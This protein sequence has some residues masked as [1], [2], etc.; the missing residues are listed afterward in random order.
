MLPRS[1]HFPSLRVIAAIAEEGRWQVQS[2]APQLG[3][4][5][6]Q[7]ERHFRLLYG[8]S[9]QRWLEDHRLRR[10]C[11]ILRTQ[12]PVKAAAQQL[13]FA[14]ASHFCGWFKRLTALTPTEFAR[15]LSVPV[16][17]RRWSPK[18]RAARM[19]RFGNQLSS[20]RAAPSC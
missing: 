20:R 8:G 13:G 5:V 1:D 6:R 14:T 19:S 3:V 12:C 7:L 18:K 17:P 15:M 9:P 4:S 16:P 11:L 2:L 10:A